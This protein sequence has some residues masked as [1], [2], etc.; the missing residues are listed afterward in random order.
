VESGGRRSLRGPLLRLDAHPMDSG[1][2]AA[3]QAAA[4]IRKMLGHRFRV[5]QGSE[6]PVPLRDA[7]RLT[8][9]PKAN[10]TPVGSH[11]DEA[12]RPGGRTPPA[13]ADSRAAT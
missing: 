3:A 4:A 9:G 13:V 2:A 7:S 6:P 5:L 11:T 12:R 8:A 10:L 1:I